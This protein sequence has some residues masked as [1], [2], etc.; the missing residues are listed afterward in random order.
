MTNSQQPILIAG[1]TGALGGLVVRKLLTAGVPVR[2]IGRNR[3][4]LSALAAVGAEIVIADLLDR[5]AVAR[6]C[7]GVAQVYSTVNNV[8]GRGTSSPN[9]VDIPAHASLCAAAREAGVRRFVFLSGRDM[10]ADSPVDFFRVKHAIENVV[11]ASGVPFVLIHASA[12]METWVGMLIDGIRKNGTAALFGD[13]RTVGNY[14]AIDDVAEFSLRILTR[15]DVVN[16]GIEIGGPS[17]VSGEQLVALIEAQLGVRAKRRH[18][19]KA[20]LWAGGSLVRPFNEVAARFM[21]MGYYT[22]TTDARF[23][24]WTTASTRFGVAPM[25]IESFVAA[26]T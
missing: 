10:T 18:V 1:A 2:A 8:M 12:F 25:S 13:G 26:L 7:E 3:E 23:T 22:A 9:R 24:D 19:P 15:P 6:A 5:A 4:K 17:N 11:R 20:V 21:R 16:E 14:I